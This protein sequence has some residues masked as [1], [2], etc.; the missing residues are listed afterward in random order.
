[1]RAH[2]ETATRA[3]SAFGMSD[4]HTRAEVRCLLK[5]SFRVTERRYRVPPAHFGDVGRIVASVSGVVF[6]R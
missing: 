5:G 1:M 2:A 4:P 3:R 6:C